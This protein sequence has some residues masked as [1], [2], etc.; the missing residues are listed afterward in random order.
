M[1]TSSMMARTVASTSGET[2]RLVVRKA[3]KRC[4][5]SAS[6]WLSVMAIVWNAQAL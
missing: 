3:A 5:K 4:S 6:D 2:S 1:R